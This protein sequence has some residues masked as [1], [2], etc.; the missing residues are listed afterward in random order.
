MNINDVVEKV[1]QERQIPSRFPSRLIFVES[2]EEYNRLIAQ[3][4]NLCDRTINLGDEEVCPVPD[5]YPDFTALQRLVDQNANKQ[6]LLLS[7]GEYLRFRLIKELDTQT[8]TFPAFWR[9]MQDASSLTR[10]FIPI[11]AGHDLFDRI[12]P[13]VDERQSDHIWLLD[14]APDEF[15]AYRLAVFSESFSDKIKNPIQ[16]LREWLRKWPEEYSAHQEARVFSRLYR[17]LEVARGHI[18]VSVFSSTFEYLRGRVLDG[19]KLIR[20]WMPDSFWSDL[21]DKIVP[22]QLFSETI[23]DVLNVKVFEPVQVLSKWDTYSSLDQPLIW[24][25]FQIYDSD[26]YCANAL[27]SIASPS[28]V[29][30]ALRDSIIG[31]DNAEWIE[32]RR[33]VLANLRSV[34][35]TPEFFA[36]LDNIEQAD[37]RLKL[38]TFKTHEEKAYAL[39]TIGEMLRAGKTVEEA[40]A[41]VGRK[42]PELHTYLTANIEDDVD[43]NQ[44][45]AWYRT[46]KLINR[47][48]E[49]DCL[50]NKLDSYKSRYSL[51][52]DES[53]ENTFVLWV[54]G[55]GVEWLP[56]LLA[57]IHVDTT[58]F[59]IRS[60]IARSLLPTETEFNTGWQDFEMPYEKINRLDKLNHTGMPDDN[61]YYS[62]IARQMETIVEVASQAEALIKSHAR[63]VVTA[64]HGSSRLAALAFHSRSGVST[65][66]NS[67]VRSHGRYCELTQTPSIMDLTSSVEQ[68]FVDEKAYLVFKD[69]G[70]YVVSGNAAG[71]NTD[72][73]PIAG[74]I[75][76]GKTPEEY[77]VP[78]I[79][80]ENKAM[81]KEMNSLKFKLAS[82]TVYSDKNVVTIELIFTGDVDELEVASGALRGVCKK[83][84]SS[85][86][87]VSFDNLADQGYSFVVVAN[88]HILNQKAIFDVKA[89]GTTVNDPFGDF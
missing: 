69:Y 67:T 76:G 46:A 47:P 68:A 2:L 55:M 60:M 36:R 24:M 6:I 7:V 21:L 53:D 42:Y 59:N 70:H 41:G 63:V 40:A 78:L 88:G 58:R 85:K 86:W 83:T 10:V 64:D 3:L 51:L 77:L 79:V 19:D 65:P 32:E 17:N 71:G 20:D 75:H 34:K 38:L 56:L 29:P 18:S 28:G 11:F 30:D 26:T 49:T 5:V 22:S 89:K 61:N 45:F 15:A 87:T 81:L 73:T 43:A 50:M 25:W 57:N 52:S 14:G 27:R 1:K 74:E 4:K 9:R 8:A 12:V 37:E 82:S 84:T 54:D 48:P 39:K 72:E 33:K 23:K 16:G 80:L 13:T 44:Y 31:S 35:Y 66:S 62:C